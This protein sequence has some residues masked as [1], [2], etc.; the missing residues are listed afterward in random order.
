MG[1]AVLYGPHRLRGNAHV[2]SV[3]PPMSGVCSEVYRRLALPMKSSQPP[4]RSMGVL[5]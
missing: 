3:R 2:Q 4:K 5:S 1:T